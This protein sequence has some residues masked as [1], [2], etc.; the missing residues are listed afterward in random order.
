M[1]S[2]PFLFIKTEEGP[3]PF[4][5]PAVIDYGHGQTVDDRPRAQDRPM[6]Q[7][8]GFNPRSL[9][10]RDQPGFSARPLESRGL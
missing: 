1:G 3:R 2:I 9:E 4:Q 7:P 10:S 6:E 5:A 8:M